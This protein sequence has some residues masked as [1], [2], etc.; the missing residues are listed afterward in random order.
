MFN[1]CF[2]GLRRLALLIW[3]ASP[4][5]VLADPSGEALKPTTLELLGP[6]GSV[7]QW[8]EKL[9][10]TEVTSVEP[11]KVRLKGRYAVKSIAG[12]ELSLNG[13][14]IE[15]D[16]EGNFEVSLPLQGNVTPIPFKF[17]DRFGKV[18]PLDIEVHAAFPA[19]APEIKPSPLPTAEA[20]PRKLNFLVGLGTTWVQYSETDIPDYSGVLLTLKGSTTYII[21]EGLWD[22]G[23]TGFATLSPLTETPADSGVRF[24]GMNFRVG[25][26][27]LLSQR[28]KVGV[29]TGGYWT[30]MLVSG[31]AFGFRNQMGPQIFPT[32]RYVLANQGAVR[33]YLKFAAIG[34]GAGLESPSNNELALGGSY[35]F[36]AK[37]YWQSAS[38]DFARL[39]VTVQGVR[40]TSNSASLVW[41]LS[42]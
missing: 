9:L 34:T 8:P 38:L 3:I 10:I 33:G 21:R 42:F 23:L 30:T 14:K 5:L 25:R 31:G 37:G 41:S 24:F 1:R 6:G 20:A 32:I 13:S 2:E 15:R 39:G 7:V 22:T 11:G 16:S 29:H 12:M 17:I 40:I 28:L 19:L 35:D 36:K 18:V 4:A 26:T 27:W